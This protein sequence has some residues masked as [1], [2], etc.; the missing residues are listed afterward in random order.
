MALMGLS[1]EGG[2]KGV[3]IFLSCVLFKVCFS[4]M[5]IGKSLFVYLPLCNNVIIDPVLNQHY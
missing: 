3:T 4:M 2:S 5:A 1:R